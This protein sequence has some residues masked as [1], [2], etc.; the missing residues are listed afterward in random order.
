ML[1]LYLD[2]SAILRATLEVGAS[3]EV[4]RRIEKAE[5]LLTSRLSIVESARVLA[6][7]LLADSKT[8]PAQRLTHAFRLA[9]ARPLSERELAVLLRGLERR[10]SEFSADATWRWIR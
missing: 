2:T 6:Q 10:K 3:P 9:T 5:V 8:T 7:T 4:E 1:A